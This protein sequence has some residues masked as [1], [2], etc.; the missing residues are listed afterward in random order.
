MSGPHGSRRDPRRRGDR[1]SDVRYRHLADV[2]VM[3]ADV[4]FWGKADIVWLD[5]PRGAPML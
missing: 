3:P 5:R 2:R 4:R 1:I